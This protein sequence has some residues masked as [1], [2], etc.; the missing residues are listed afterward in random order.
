LP[1]L[2]WAIKKGKSLYTIEL[3]V[4]DSRASVY[5]RDRQG[6]DALDYQKIYQSSNKELKILLKRYR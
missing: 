5:V 6:R 4:K 3:I 2:L 1:P